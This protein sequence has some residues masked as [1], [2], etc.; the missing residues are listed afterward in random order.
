MAS[1]ADRLKAD[2]V[3]IGGGSA[4]LVLANRLSEDPGTTVILV[5][6]GG[7]S[8]DFMVQ[9]PAGF[10]K[11]VGNKERD[12][13]Y[14]QEPDP[15][16]ND[17]Q[18]IW[19]A[20][21]M[22][23]GGSSINGQVYIRGTKRDYDHWQETGAD[24][25]SYDELLPYFRRLEGWYGE[26]DQ[27]HGESGPLSVGPMRDPHPFVDYFLQAC[28]DTGLPTLP[29]PND[30]RMEGAFET[31]TSQRDGWRCSTEKAYLRP[32][33]HRANL[34]VLTQAEVKT[35]RV[36]DGRSVGVR[37]QRAGEAIDI[38]ANREVILCA[39]AMGSPGLLLRSG[40]GDAATLTA[41]GID[42]VH[43]LAGV[44]RN[45]QEHN[46]IRVSKHVAQPTLNSDLGTWRMVR[47]ALRF[48]LARKGILS[49]P[50]VQAM[51]LAKTDPDLD[52][53]DVQLHFVP[54]CMDMDPA[55]MKPGKDWAV[56]MAATICHPRTRGHIE[57]AADGR[58]KVVHRYLGEERDLD[59]LIDG[60]RLIERVFAAPAFA[61]LLRGNRKPDPTPRT[62][63]EWTDFL[64][65]TSS[66]AFHP[67]GTC[68][69]G[70]DDEAVVD[71]ALRV[72]GL[73]GLRVVDASVMP[74]ITST[75]TNA[76]TI[77]IAERAADLIRQR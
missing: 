65:E 8:K 45:L 42:V 11:L 1:N 25:W 35:V 40:I 53:P 15:S 13:R 36:V 17:R 34:T 51:A 72:R 49:S 7:E 69:M 20:G 58:P 24:G 74:R 71:P 48:G 63:D 30:G 50:I 3:I 27:I 37:G 60:C 39:G 29:R 47:H 18:T 61:P 26:P 70:V 22:L 31:V 77:M 59:T 76:T 57:L 68:R 16:I 55:T 52:E 12:W 4:G 66:A 44:G 46:N 28:A 64:R 56:T 14:E 43:H 9:L 75:N 54:L 21:K 10:G 38:D 5:E 6:A 32:A 2:Y 67:V 19:S 23:G 73:R 62:R 33:R 41:S